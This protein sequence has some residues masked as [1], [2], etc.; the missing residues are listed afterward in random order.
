M[1]IRSR[2]SNEEFETLMQDVFVAL[3]RN[4]SSRDLSIMALGN[5]LTNIFNN[6]VS[7]DKREVLVSQFCDA[8]TKSTLHNRDVTKDT[9]S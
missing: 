8:L 9:A 1:P 5:V 3:E 6:Q 4:R 7:A 2:Y